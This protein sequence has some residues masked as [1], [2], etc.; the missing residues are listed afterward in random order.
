MNVNATYR[1]EQSA[2]GMARPTDMS[3]SSLMHR[4]ALRPRMRA[5]PGNVYVIAIQRAQKEEKN[6]DVMHR[7]SA[8]SLHGDS[9]GKRASGMEGCSLQRS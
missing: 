8:N 2:I 3:E 1:P 9:H 4:A 7:T 5:L 6:R